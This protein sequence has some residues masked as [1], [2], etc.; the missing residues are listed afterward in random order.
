MDGLNR[1]EMSEE[2]EHKYRWI[3][4]CNLNKEKKEFKNIALSNLWGY[5]KRSNTGIH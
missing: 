5:T 3:E 1:I 4:L 2:S